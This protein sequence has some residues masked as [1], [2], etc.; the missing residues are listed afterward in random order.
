MGWR[1]VFL[2]FPMVLFL[3]DICVLAGAE[4][5]QLNAVT[6]P[7]PKAVLDYS[8]EMSTQQDDVSVQTTQNSAVTVATIPL[9]HLPIPPLPQQQKHELPEGETQE[10]EEYYDAGNGDVQ[11]Y[12]GNYGEGDAEEGDGSLE[13]PIDLTAV[14]GGDEQPADERQVRG[15]PGTYTGDQ[16]VD[17]VSTLEGS[18]SPDDQPALPAVEA[19]TELV[20]DEGA[21]T[22]PVLVDAQAA[23]TIQRRAS[24]YKRRH[25]DVEAEEDEDSGTCSRACDMFQFLTLRLQGLKS[26]A[27]D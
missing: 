14:D 11:E 8:Q 23:V 24:G 20:N 4:Q 26:N 27:R 2:F 18:L 15:D 13:Q 19:G 9:H 7:E 22:D 21:G 16:D 5:E 12:Y 17:E 3:A 6:E 1:F 10:P 25:E